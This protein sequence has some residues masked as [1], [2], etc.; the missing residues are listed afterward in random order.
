LE[1]KFLVQSF[2]NDCIHQ[3]KNLYPPIILIPDM[4]SIIEWGR[5]G[6]KGY[7]VLYIIAYY[8]KNRQVGARQY[9]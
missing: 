1:E 2:A 6:R 8:I 7:S 3:L 4:H 5:G 9:F